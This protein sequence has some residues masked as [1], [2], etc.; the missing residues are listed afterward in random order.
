MSFFKSNFNIEQKKIH[1]IVILLLFDF[2]L[3]IKAL[4]F[5]PMIYIFSSPMKCVTET[6]HPSPP[7]QSPSVIFYNLLWPTSQKVCP[8]LPL[9]LQAETPL[10]QSHFEMQR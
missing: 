8:A 10:E 1:F 9:T 7:G 4:F 6:L 2:Q 3:I 5:Y